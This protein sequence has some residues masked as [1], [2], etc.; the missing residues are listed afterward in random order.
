MAYRTTENVN[1]S[2]GEFVD[3]IVIE[4]DPSDNAESYILYRD[5]IWLGLAQSDSELLYVDEFADLYTNH[6][7]CIEAEN[8]C[9]LSELSCDTGYLSYGVG[10]MNSD[11]SVDVLDVVLVVNIILGLSEVDDAT[12]WAGDINN[13]GTINI[14]DVILLISIILN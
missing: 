3:Q 10:D 9:G 5:G 12:L 14:Q 13:D 11:N 2:D 4:W 6:E 1:A 8:E 7:Y